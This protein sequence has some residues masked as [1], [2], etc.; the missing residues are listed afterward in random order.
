MMC[1]DEIKSNSPK[2]ACQAEITDPHVAVLVKQDVCRFQVSVND[3]PEKRE[4][5]FV[6]IHK[7]I[8]D[9]VLL[10]A[11]DMSIFSVSLKNRSQLSLSSVH[12]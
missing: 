11:M 1:G 6:E 4:H 7:A 5:K 8:F 2:I 3:I 12:S 9:N 10:F